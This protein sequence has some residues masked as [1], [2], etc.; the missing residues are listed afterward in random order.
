MTQI[1]LTDERHI[2]HSNEEKVNIFLSNIDSY[3][4]VN[5]PLNI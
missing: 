3:I 5:F 1:F 4:C 2:I